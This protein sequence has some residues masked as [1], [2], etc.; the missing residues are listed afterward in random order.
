[1]GKTKQATHLLLYI[2]LLLPATIR[3]QEMSV[4]TYASE[5]L[6]DIAYKLYADYQ[7][8]CYNTTVKEVDGFAIT[9]QKDKF[10]KVT[11]IG[12]KLFA[13]EL[14]AQYPSI[15][16]L[17]IE[18]YFLDLYLLK[19]ES[20]ITRQMG[21]DK[22]H[23]RFG[24]M[25]PKSKMQE[26]LAILIPLASKSHSLTI[27]SENNVNTVTCNNEKGNLFEARFPSDYQLLSGMNKKECESSFYT[28]LLAFTDEPTDIPAATP[29]ALEK[30]GSNCYMQKGETYQIDAMN[31]HRYYA[32]QDGKFKQLADINRAEQSIHNIFTLQTD[33]R[34]EANITLR[35]YGHK[36]IEFSMP[37]HKLLGFCKTNGC[38][39][40]AGIESADSLQVK[41]TAILLNS[42]DGYNHL[43]AFEVS[44]NVLD[45]P[46]E[47]AMKVNFH[48][49]TPNHNIET[50][51]YENKQKK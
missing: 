43:L 29:H 42:V 21:E 48:I 50:L 46:E 10:K 11:H 2:L 32:S 14:T 37:L 4:S 18:R 47:Y 41:G 25:I 31:T 15:A 1:M 36:K 30:I 5:K 38:R 19:D 7:I 49:F 34:I 24:N 28:S 17:F 12:F 23:L 13:D 44:P 9:I 26:R 40:F 33:K 16:Y 8:D 39:I 20:A 51:F 35:L 6:Q 45:R 27:N 3:S 22:V